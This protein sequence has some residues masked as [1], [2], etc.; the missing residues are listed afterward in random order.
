MGKLFVGAINF[1]DDEFIK[2]THAQAKCIDYLKL[3]TDKE[4]SI[5]A[6]V[7][8]GFAYR[9]QKSYCHFQSNW[10]IYR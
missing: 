3:M 1:A 10:A 9:L 7:V 6:G 4:Q 8:K 2:L 5:E